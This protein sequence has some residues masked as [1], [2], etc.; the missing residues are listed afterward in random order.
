VSNTVE[1]GVQVLLQQNL[2]VAL[3]VAMMIG[4]AGAQ[5]V[6]TGQNPASPIVRISR[7]SSWGM[8]G[9][10]SFLVIEPGSIHWETHP[11]YD[12]KVKGIP[13]DQRTW[14]ITK[15]DWEGLRASIEEATLGTFRRSQNLS[16]LCRSGGHLGGHRVQRWNK[17]SGLI[18]L[19]TPPTLIAGLLRKIDTIA[20]NCPSEMVFSGGKPTP[21]VSDVRPA[22][23][24][25]AVYPE[26]ARSAKIQGSVVVYVIVGRRGDVETVTAASGPEKLRQAAIDAVQQ[27]KWNPLRLNRKPLRFRTKAVVHFVLDKKNTSAK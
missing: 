14:R 11:A 19:F 16:R 20:A 7:G 24:V 23:V 15:R 26:S 17:E 4:S 1:A 6:A 13:D 5:K 18:R 21:S 2:E 8:S 25:E 27:W 9:S 10:G 22:K 3:F 12:W